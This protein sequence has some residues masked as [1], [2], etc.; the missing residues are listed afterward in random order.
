[1]RADTVLRAGDC[2][3]SPKG[4]ANGHQLVNRPDSMVCCF[5]IGSRKPVEDDCD[6]PDSDLHIGPGRDSGHARKD[7]AVPV[8]ALNAHPMP[9]KWQPTARVVHVNSGHGTAF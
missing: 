3:A 5:E 7:D 8:P 4:E 6:H 2:T 1:M 9:A